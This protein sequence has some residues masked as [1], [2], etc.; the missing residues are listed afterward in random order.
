[1]C[2]I[3]LFNGFGILISGFIAMEHGASGIP[4]A[5]P[6]LPRLVFQHHTSLRPYR[7]KKLLEPASYRNLS[8]L[9]AHGDPP[10]DPHSRYCTDGILQLAPSDR[11]C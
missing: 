4:L 6:R 8:P 3:Q 5:D 2:D 10:H 1:M 7:P 11:I 9:R